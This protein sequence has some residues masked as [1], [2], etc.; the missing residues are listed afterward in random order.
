MKKIEQFRSMVLRFEQARRLDE[1][2]EACEPHMNHG[3]Y[4]HGDLTCLE[5]ILV[6]MEARWR[7]TN[8]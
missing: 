3:T 6:W 7:A 4:H 1:L 8:Q 5:M 2:L